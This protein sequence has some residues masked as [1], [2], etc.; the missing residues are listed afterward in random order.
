MTVAQHGRSVAV[1]DVVIGSPGALAGIVPGDVIQWVDGHTALGKDPGTV[2]ALLNG[3]EGTEL[4]MGW[5][6][7]RWF[8]ARRDSEAH[9]DTAGN[10]VP[11]RWIDETR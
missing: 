10:R 9:H 2:A 4:R 8:G 5:L 3:P 6:R 7:S 1:R 11:V